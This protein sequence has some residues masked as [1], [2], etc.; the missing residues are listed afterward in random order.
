M[1]FEKYYY[2]LA[3]SRIE[4]IGDVIAKKLIRHCGSAEA[5][6]KEKKSN[7]L[8]IQGVG[9][10]LIRSLE[11]KAVFEQT[12]KEL[13]FI[14]TNSIELISFYDNHYPF[15]LKECFDAP[16]LLFQKGRIQLKKPHVISIVGTRQITA[17]GKDFLKRL[18]IEIKKYNPI[19]ISGLAYGV[20]ILSH[21]LAIEHNLQTI[22]VLAHGLDKIYPPAHQKEAK[23]MQENGGLLTEFW[24]GSNP[25]REN[26][27]KRNR[28]VAGL[29]QATLVI[30]SAEKGGSLITADLAN[31]Y[32][33]DVFALPGRVTDAFSS[34]CNNLIKTNRASVLTSAKD[35]AYILNW[36]KNEELNGKGV[37][38]Q[39]FMDLPDEE[40]KI[41]NYLL[42]EGKQQLDVIALHC[43]YPIHKTV[44]VLFNL[45][46][47][48]VIRPLPGKY[49][50]A[51]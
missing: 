35:L 24:S 43:N 46:L 41:Y 11:N 21:Q 36:E 47:K 5:V 20:D 51:I 2:L 6:F 4:H 16:L 8:K 17:Y 23:K 40:Q 19:I 13:K 10:S 7:L 49:F 14:D 26:F 15:R 12:E 44:S 31:S 9:K 39:L 50:E 33:R 45:E 32:N 28:I 48:S 1:N 18:F 38:K 37:Q 3:L 34:G 22:A 25:D 29:S 27:V 30:E 42:E